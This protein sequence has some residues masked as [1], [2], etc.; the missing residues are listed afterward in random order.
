MKQKINWDV[1]GIA[2]SL[3]CAVHCALLPLFFTS[4]PVLGLEVIE[5]SFFEMVMAVLAFIIGIRALAH[6]Y[7][8]HH[9]SVLP[10]VIFTFG[11]FFLV[12]KV[13]FHQYESLLLIPAVMG[14]VMA[15]FVNYR[16]C[17]LRSHVH[18]HHCVEK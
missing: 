8:K 16:M 7:K 17:K 15:H 11:F 6:G 4:I 14:L 3:A 9:R 18:S 13:S 5:N 12:L 10:M 1:L 2:A